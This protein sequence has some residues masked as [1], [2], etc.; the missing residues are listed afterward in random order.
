M[1]TDQFSEIAKLHLL[2]SAATK[3]R[4]AESELA[5][6][7]SAAQ[8]LSASFESGGKVMLCGNGGSAAD[9]QH[10]AA[11]FVSVL[12]Q[13]FKRPGLK[14]IALTT[15]TSLLTAYANDFG[16]DGI[17]AR[18]VE[19]LGAPGDTLIGISTSGN[20]KNVIQ[21]VESAR[22]L[23]MRMI[24]LT[25]SGGRLRDLVDVVISVPS[26]S[27]QHIQEAHITIGHILCDL[28]ERHMFDK[29]TG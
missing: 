11:E 2:Q 14:A 13:E 28:V 18:Q 15:D 21:A 4:L 10:I 17:F 19:T 29:N 20:S 22:K 9:C 26:Q 27:T 8:L 12:T 24:G 7:V 5:P 3:Q 6:I 23:K 1:N 16:F 25:G